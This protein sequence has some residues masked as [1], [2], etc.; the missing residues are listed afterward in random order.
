MRKNGNVG[1][2]TKGKGGLREVVKVNEIPV[3]SVYSSD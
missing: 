3:K 1:I 2:E